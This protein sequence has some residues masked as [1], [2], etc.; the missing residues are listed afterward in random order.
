[1][2]YDF[3]TKNCTACLQGFY[4]NHTTT[5]KCIQCP[6]GQTTAYSGSNKCFQ[7]TGK[8]CLRMFIWEESDIS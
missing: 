3:A 1:M 2:E 5:E 4:T 8:D 6:S 7:N